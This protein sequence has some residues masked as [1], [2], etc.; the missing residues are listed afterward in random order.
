[1][2]TMSIIYLYSLCLKYAVIQ[3]EYI[4]DKLHS[5]T[6]CKLNDLGELA[7][8]GESKKENFIKNFAKKTS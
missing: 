1:M 5:N 2:Y 6:I 4:N 8:L 7:F 3:D